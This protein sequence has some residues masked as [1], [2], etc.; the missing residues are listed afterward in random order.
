MANAGRDDNG[1]QF[2]FT[3]SSVPD[4]QHKHTIFGR[5]TGESIY[6]MLQLE[7]ALV[8][9]NDRL[10]YPSRLLKSIILNNPF[11]DIVPRIIVEESEEVKD[12]SKTKTAVVNGK[13]KSSHDH[14]T[15]PK[16]NSE[17]AVKPSG[18]ANKR[19]K[20]DRSNDWESD[21][22]IKA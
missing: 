10:L 7:E 15:D 20:E 8:D 3:L 18:L 16:L 5:V 12:N 9:E 1:S 6:N 2:F 4:L 19:R 11:S 22:E 21:N 14:L 13:G 17:P